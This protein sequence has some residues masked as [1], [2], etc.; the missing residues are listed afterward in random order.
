MGSW[1]DSVA[2]PLDPRVRAMVLM[3]GGATD[4]ARVGP[5][6]RLLPQV[7]AADPLL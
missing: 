4:A 7:G 3:V 2:G 5:A 1:L 6:L